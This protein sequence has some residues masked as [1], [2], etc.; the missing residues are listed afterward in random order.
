MVIF[1]GESVF[2]GFCDSSK[3]PSEHEGVFEGGEGGEGFFEV[4]EAGLGAAA[5]AG[6][7]EVEG[8][9]A[10]IAVVAGYAVGEKIHRSQGAVG[11]DVAPHG[12]EGYAPECAVKYG[13]GHICAVGGS[14]RKQ[15]AVKRHAGPHGIRLRNVHWMAH[16]VVI[17]LDNGIG[18]LYGFRRGFRVVET[19]IGVECPAQ[20][21]TGS[22][23]H[24]AIS[25]SCSVKRDVIVD[26]GGNFY[27]FTKPENVSPCRD[28][29]RS[30]VHGRQ[31]YADAETKLTGVAGEGVSQFGKKCYGRGCPKCKTSVRGR[32]WRLQHTAGFS[33]YNSGHYPV[34]ASES[35]IVDAAAICG[36]TAE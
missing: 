5:K 2:D 4:A 36:C 32:E 16:C 29:S 9:Q 10:F 6:G 20:I 28:F 33:G 19:Q 12:V 17:G 22:G 15:I 18:A 13:G 35:Q 24:S 23:S 25:G 14:D 1:S 27:S 30:H 7:A 34:A 8:F 21:T 11:G 3:Q 26:V 31:G